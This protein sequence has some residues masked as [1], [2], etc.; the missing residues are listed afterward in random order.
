[1]RVHPAALSNFVT[2]ESGATDMTGCCYDPSKDKIFV[3]Y[4]DA[5]NSEYGTMVVGTISSGT[6]SFGTPVVFN[7]SATQYV[8]CTFLCG[9]SINKP[10][11]SYSASTIGRSNVINISGTTPT[12]GS[13]STFPSNQNGS[14]FACCYDSTADRAIT[15]FYARVVHLIT[16]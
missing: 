13:Q 3:A 10:Y 8:A 5:G 16:A 4:V 15:V 2:F 1:M 7:S 11:I 9:G 12:A 6:V 14:H